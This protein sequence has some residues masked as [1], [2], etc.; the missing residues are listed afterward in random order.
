MAP[1]DVVP[2]DASEIYSQV[3]P[4]MDYLEM[5]KTN[6]EIYLAHIS[7]GFASDQA[8]ELTRTLVEAFLTAQVMRGD[9]GE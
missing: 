2:D 1:E 6:R 8:F 4:H 7:A 3:L 5:A 9:H